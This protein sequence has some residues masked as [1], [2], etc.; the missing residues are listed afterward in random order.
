MATTKANLNVECDC[1]H[2]RKFHFQNS[3][4]CSGICNLEGKPKKYTCGC[5]WYSPNYNWCL[6]Q[7][8]N[9]IMNQEASNSGKILMIQTEIDSLERL[10]FKVPAQWHKTILALNGKQ[11]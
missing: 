1:G 8:L 4:Q 11:H 3:G 7:K 5:T 6:K 9:K 2:L 10:N